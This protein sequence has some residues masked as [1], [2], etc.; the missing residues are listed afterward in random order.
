MKPI[1]RPIPPNDSKLFKTGLYESKNEFEH[2]WHFHPEIELTYIVSSRGAR[3]VGNSIENYSEDDLVLLGC[4]LPHCWSYAPEQ[5]PPK[6][7]VVYLNE[8]FLNDAWMQSNEFDSIRKLLH[9]SN[10]GIKFDKSVTLKLKEQL[11]ELHRLTS[12][13]R[14]ISLLQIL[15]ELARTS[16]YHL[17]CGSGYS[18]ELD[19]NNNERINAV[20]KFLE[21]N[22]QQKI[23]LSVISAEVNMSEEYFSRFFSKIMRKPFV[24]FLN[25]YRINKA[26]RLLIETDKQIS[27]ICYAVGFE[28]IPFFYRQFKRFRNCQPKKYRISYNNVSFGS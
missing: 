18:Y 7:S 2:P 5:H 16:H 17:L 8:G 9:L 13:D 27:E 6:S 11:F 20:Y 28:S 10:R 26:C 19:Q 4:N 24:E 1:Y 14:I 3:Y 23:S 12:V 15:K 22:Y 21:K 25:E